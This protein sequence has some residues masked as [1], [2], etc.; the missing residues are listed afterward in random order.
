MYK[1]IITVLLSF[2]L[3]GCVLTNLESILSASV[4]EEVVEVA[5]LSDMKYFLTDGW[6]FYLYHNKLVLIKYTPSGMLI[7]DVFKVLE[8]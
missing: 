6:E 8:D 7:K 3:S 2:L 4:T 1:Y 5:D